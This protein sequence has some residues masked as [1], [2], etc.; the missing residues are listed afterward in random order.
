M[1]N[2]CASVATSLDAIV[3]ENHELERILVQE[4]DA[5]LSRVSAFN[6]AFKLE[7]SAWEIHFHHA[8]RERRNSSRGLKL[9][10]D[11]NAA[12]KD[13]A[14]RIRNYMRQNGIEEVQ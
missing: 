6:L 4:K 9:F 13:H 14:D 2:G 12:D 11:L 1:S 8:M 5:P 3:N 7:E 10:Q